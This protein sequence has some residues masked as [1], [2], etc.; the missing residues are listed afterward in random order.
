MAEIENVITVHY[1]DPQINKLLQQKTASTV[2]GEENTQHP[3]SRHFSQSEDF[4]LQLP[5]PFTVPSFPIHHDIYNKRPEKGYL[6]RLASMVEQIIDIVPEI[7]AELNYFF[8]P[9]ENL[10]PCFYR[11]YR[12][13]DQRYLYL[14][15][16]DLH[17]RAQYHE[18]IQRGTNDQTPEYSSNHLFLEANFIPL[19]DLITSDDRISAFQ[20]LQTISQTWIGETGRGYFVQGI[21]IDN[22]LTKFFT[23]TI[24]P[25]G[26]RTYPFYPLIC[27]YKTICE[28][29]IDLGPEKRKQSLP[30][31]HKSIRFFL[32]RMEEIQETM[33]QNEFSEDIPLFQKTKAAAPLLWPESW[34]D[35][36]LR[37]YLNEQE[38]R[39]YV[40]EE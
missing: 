10:R 14:L 9:A 16:L 39:E 23:K 6:D 13:E 3:V 2:K 11:V 17:Y 20:I 12:I 26:K 8:D 28:T 1:A 31:L 15:R 35:L 24:V 38:M 34:K 27:K 5:K 37:V 40:L 4:F 30:L 19:R 33:R 36:K 21:W 32:P 7:F 18:L 25:Q 22:D 29:V